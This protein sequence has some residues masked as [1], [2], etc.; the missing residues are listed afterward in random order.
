MFIRSA[1]AERRPISLPHLL[2]VEGSEDGRFYDQ[3]CRFLEINDRIEIRQVGG[4]T[5]F[6]SQL[7]AVAALGTVVRTIS[8]IRDADSSP[9]GAFQSV[10]DAFARA[11]LPV[12]STARAP[13]ALD[14]E[15]RS[16]SVLIVPSAGPGSIE[17]VCWNTLAA[18]PFVRCVDPFLACMDAAGGGATL[19]TEAAQAKRRIWSLLAA[20]C[21][22]P[23]PLNAGLRLGEAAEQ[24]FWDWA[25]PAFAPI[26]EFLRQQVDGITPTR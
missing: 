12:P 16:T 21:V 23:R 22:V 14:A 7:K 13:T 1:A 2:L 3:L 26:A 5:E 15:G 9:L 19:S 6:A 25:H 17:T 8:V 10:C 24:G 20:G 4:W 11:R 18:L